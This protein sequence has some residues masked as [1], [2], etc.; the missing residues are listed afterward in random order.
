MTDGHPVFS[1]ADAAEAWRPDTAA[2]QL[3]R[4][5]GDAARAVAK[6]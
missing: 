1:D 3:Y 6:Y 5:L 2:Q 4:E